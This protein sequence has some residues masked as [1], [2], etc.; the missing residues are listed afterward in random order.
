[1][2][3]KV[4]LRL[5]VLCAGITAA[6]MIIMSLCYLYISETG[7]Y[8]NQFNSFK[9]DINTIA[10]NLEQQ[11]VISMEWLS[12][13]EAQGNYAFLVLDNNV[14][15]LYNRLSAS[16]GSPNSLI[17][18]EGLDFYRQNFK[19]SASPEAPP[20]P[21]LSYH[22]EYRFQS[23]SAREYYF[24]S[25]ITVEKNSSLLQIVVVSPL[26]LMEKQIFQQRIRFLFIDLAAVLL[27]ALF[28]WFFTGIL[29]RPIQESQQRQTH[30]IAAASHE[31]RTPLAVILSSAE[32]FKNVDSAQQDSF[33]NTIRQEG[34]RMSRLIEDMLTL[35]ESDIHRFSIQK[36]P[37]ELDTLLLNT[38]EAF[39]VLAKEHSLSLS[40]A[41][42]DTP[43]PM[44]IC[45]PD[46]IRQVISILLHNAVSYTQAQG[47]IRVSLTHKRA[48]GKANFFLSVSDNGIGI[49]DEDKKKIFDRFFRAEK[50]RSAKG[51][52]GLGLS[53]AFEIV[54]A[55]HGNI[56]VA[57][58]K[59]GGSVFT[60]CLPEK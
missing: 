52:F 12:K 8:R 44:C 39:E 38:C 1:M 42:P 54:H 47:K 4:H 26:N 51:H 17:L 10:T 31:L 3:K 49:S 21:Y 9:N 56:T 50:S 34:L 27:F 7:L 60:V 58:S 48:S 15:F 2:Y 13:M 53:I 40:L 25:V 57:D 45:D 37:V 36:N 11:S 6:L 18:E 59:E 24:G 33:L 46:R 14:P 28:S 30:F 29:L 16:P 23:P 35:T 22:T 20:S 19:A 5:T 41:L 43:L 32:C 55:H